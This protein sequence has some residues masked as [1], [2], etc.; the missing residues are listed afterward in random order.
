MRFL[1]LDAEKMADHFPA[2]AFDV[3]WIS[4]A[5]SHFP[6]KALFFRNAQRVLRPGGRLVLA[7]WFKAPGLSTAAFDADIKPIEDGM[8]L[9]PLCTQDDYVTLATGAGLKTKAAPRDI[10]G[11]VSQTWYVRETNGQKQ[12]DMA[13]T[14][15]GR[16][17]RTRRCGRLR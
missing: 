16:W 10:S 7:D 11:D 13:G 6:D 1:E 2:D 9:P 4:E 14:S 15:R 3:V 8:L 5:L 17:C 12:A